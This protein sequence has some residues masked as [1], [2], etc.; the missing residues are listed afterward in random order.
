MC[1]FVTFW[2]TC[3]RTWPTKNALWLR[4]WSLQCW[5]WKLNPNYTI[6]N[7]CALQSQKLCQVEVVQQSLF[8]GSLCGCTQ[9]ETSRNLQSNYTH[10]HS[11]EHRTRQTY[12][13]AEVIPCTKILKWLNLQS[14]PPLQ[15]CSRDFTHKIIIPLWTPVKSMLFGCLFLPHTVRHINT[16]FI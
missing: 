9:S 2:H 11:L 15:L 14:R 10:I 13:S 7:D 16:P 12:L 6:L 1:A 8:A 5:Y 4:L 3:M